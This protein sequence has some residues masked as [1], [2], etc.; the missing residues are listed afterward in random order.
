MGSLLLGWLLL[1][2]LES[3]V[4]VQSRDVVVDVDTV[5]EV[6]GWPRLLSLPEGSLDEE[7]RARSPTSCYRNVR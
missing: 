7:V 4:L 2:L 3:L 5:G 1:D 6:D